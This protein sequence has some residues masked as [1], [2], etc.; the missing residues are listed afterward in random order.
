MHENLGTVPSSVKL[1]DSFNLKS[2]I[3]SFVLILSI[4][5]RRRKS[6][7]KEEGKSY[8]SIITFMQADSQLGGAPRPEHFITNETIVRLN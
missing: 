7:I 1:S 2:H 5:K 6:L 8:I 3:L 4:K